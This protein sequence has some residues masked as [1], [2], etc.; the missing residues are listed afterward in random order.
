MSE[1]ILEVKNLRAYYNIL[2][3]QVK[4]V[5]DITFNLKKGEILGLAGE[6]GCGKSTL[7][8]SFISRKKPLEYV[9]GE[10]DLVGHEIMKM[11][12]AE[13]KKLRLK[14]ISII[15]QYA[16]DAFSPTK[17]IRT[18]IKD[19]AHQHGIKT[20]RAFMEKVE[21]R[22]DLVNL[23]KSVLN[24]YSIELSGGMKQRV[25]MVISTILDPD[26]IIADEITSALDVSSQRF[27]A[28]ML[29]NLRDLEIIKSAIFITHD[30]SILYQI[31]DRI[32]IMYAG[33]FAEIAP[34][35]EIVARP[36]HPYTR[37]LI[38]SLPKVGIQYHDKRL[39]GI[40]GTPPHLL[41]IGDGC[42]FRDRCPYAIEKCEETPIREKVADNHYVSC[43]RWQELGSDLN[44]EE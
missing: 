35:D 28:T 18:F 7:A 25:V 27:V 13:F 2:K 33:N 31:A 11:D 39:S 42:R 29:A 44:V 43:W 10:V 3:G 34:T 16:L 32:M 23:D 1:N 41:N 6:S 24:R 21:E 19:L 14:T 26:F 15:P 12:E 17:K 36:R 8:S 4:A 22:L 38:N 20:D 5:D 30:L 37:A 40:E 9:S